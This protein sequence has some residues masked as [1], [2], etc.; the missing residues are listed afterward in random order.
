LSYS[1][2]TSTLMGIIQL[3]VPVVTFAMGYLLTNIGYKRDRKLSIVREKFEKLYHPFYL[4]VHELGTEKEEGFAVGGET[5]EFKPFLNHLTKNAHLASSQGQQLIWE[6]RSLFISC[7]AG[8]S[9]DNEK[10][11][12]FETS[13]HALFELLILEYV[14]SAKTLGYELIEYGTL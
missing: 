4:L 14:K 2:E 11:Q 6:T 3:F 5:S 13:V 1:G 10:E 9:V 8:D 7:T 12:L